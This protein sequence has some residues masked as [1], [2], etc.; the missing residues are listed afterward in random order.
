MKFR[1]SLAAAFCFLLP[2]MGKAQ[3]TGRVECPRSGGYVYLYSSMITL[4]V[5]TTLQ[6]GEELQIT[7]R[8]DE[9][10]GV[11]TSKGE[12]GYVPLGAIVL[13]KDKPGPQ[14]SP[15]TG[16]KPARERTPYDDTPPPPEAPVAAAVGPEFTLRN[17]TPV[18]LKV[19][20]SISSATAHVGDAVVLEVA[21]DV[22]VEGLCVIPKG[23]AA[24]GTV[25]EAEA[26][27]RMGHGGK[28]GVLANSVILD[29][30]EKAAVRGYEETGGANSATG[31]V[32]PM[33]SGKDVVL[34]QGTEFTAWVDGDVKLK[35][36]AF[37]APKPAPAAVPA[38]AP[39]GQSPAPSPK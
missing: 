27:K 28:V 35:R 15:G 24:A 9:Y 10:F 32:L 3:N 4:D 11:K 22:V 34:G 39:A 29:N 17:G 33:V 7:G 26:K 6:C 36:E 14:V 13:L 1:W 38:A 2:A 21:A 30:A 20:K 37:S 18:H 31:T 8:F 23:A 5:R 16:A 25:T 12:T 19:S